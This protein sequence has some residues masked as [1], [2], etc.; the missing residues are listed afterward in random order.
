VPST[1]AAPKCATEISK[2]RENDKRRKIERKI[3]GGKENWKKNERN[4]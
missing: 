1:E 2:N 3:E 4:K